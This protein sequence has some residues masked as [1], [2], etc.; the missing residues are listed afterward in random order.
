MKNLNLNCPIGFTGYGIT[1]LNIFKE[2]QKQDIDITLFLMGNGNVDSPEE[3]QILIDAIKKQEKF[4]PK[5]ASLKIWHPHDLGSRTGK[6]Y[7]GALTFFEI[8]RLKPL[9]IAMINSTD[10]IFVASEWAKQILLNNSITTNIVVSPLGADLSIFNTSV[11]NTQEDLTSKGNKYVFLNI[12]KWEIRK[13]HDFLIDAFNAAFTKDDNVELWMV[14]YNPFLNQEENQKWVTLY[15]TSKL[16]D[17]IK[18][19][20]R[21]SSHHDLAKVISL[22]DCGIYPARAEGWNNAIMEIMAM[23]KPVILSNYSAHTEYATKDNSYLIDIDNTCQAIDNKF[24]DGFGNW[25]NLDDNQFEQTVEHMKFVYNNNI[26]TN[27]N[28]LNTAQNYTWAKTASIIQE[29]LFR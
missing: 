10:T 17:K 15:K 1:S 6:G 19:I 28:G 20:P 24:F 4:D 13:G 22:S 5:S 21:L 2:L 27:E 18:I 25:A 16:A 29:N 3:Q 14:S 7:Y 23:N 11:K 8:D 9:E 26:R 12:G